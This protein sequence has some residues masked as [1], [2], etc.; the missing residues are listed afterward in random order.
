MGAESQMKVLWS[1]CLRLQTFC[2]SQTGPPGDQGPD[3]G[4]PVAP[5]PWSRCLIAASR[6]LGELRAADALAITAPLMILQ[7]KRK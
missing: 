2:V 7:K 6:G 1:L 3:P 5:G 4:A